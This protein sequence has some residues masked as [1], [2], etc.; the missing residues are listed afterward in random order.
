MTS[1]VPI[2]RLLTI[3]FSAINQQIALK[4]IRKLGF[5][6]TAVWNGKEALDYLLAADNPTPIHQKPDI[7][8]MDVQM[9]IIDGYRATHLIR[10]HSPYNTFAREIPIVAMTASAIQGDREKCQKA[11]M[12]DYLAKPVKGTTLEKMLVRWTLNSRSPRTS[13][14]GA[15]YSG[16]ECSES[17]EH[18]CGTPAVPMYG[19]GKSKKIHTPPTPT[20]E[21]PLSRP[22][23]TERQNSH[24]LVL[25]GTETEGDRIERREHAEEKASSLRDEK[26]V[27]LA[28]STGTHEHA[29]PHSHQVTPSEE[30]AEPSLLLTIENIGKLEQEA[31]SRNSFSLGPS[32][33]RLRREDTMGSV[34]AVKGADSPGSNARDRGVSAERPRL[35]TDRRFRDSDRTITHFDRGEDDHSGS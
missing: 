15:P 1:R 13:I 23:I 12:D 20:K 10:H 16:S 3:C 31:G 7:I 25:P 6:V 29:L 9:P 26:L 18:N 11:G 2:V 19:Q 22:T 30:I 32:K 35:S 14:Q 8:L 24:R 21:G 5:N 34:D 27:D 28:Y 33:N 4:T 17:E